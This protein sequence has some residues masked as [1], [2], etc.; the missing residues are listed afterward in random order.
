MNATAWPLIAVLTLLPLTTVAHDLSRPHSHTSSIV[1]LASD[2]Q[3]H[4]AITVSAAFARASAG[5]VKTGAAYLTIHNAG[6]ETDR[7]IA[8]KADIAKRVELHTHRHEGGV[9]KMRPIESVEVPAGGM[10]VLKPGG[11]HVMFMGLKA[12]LKQG[13]SFPLTLVFENAGTVTITIE[14]GPV[15]AMG[16]SHGNN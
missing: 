3:R 10:A 5:P 1:Q 16:A 11:D 7:L 6:A 12:P 14:I 9:M 8:A 13:E 15:G 4:K 2:S